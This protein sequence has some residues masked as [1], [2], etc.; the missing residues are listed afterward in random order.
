[1]GSLRKAS[2]LHAEVP[3]W[4]KEQPVSE[5]Q[6]EL[7]GFSHRTQDLL[8]KATERLGYL[9]DFQNSPVLHGAV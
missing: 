5:L 8:E 9:R 7:V 4:L 1:M 2:W 3:Q 6:A